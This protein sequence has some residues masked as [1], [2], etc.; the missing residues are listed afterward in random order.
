MSG[1]LNMMRNMTEQLYTSDMTTVGRYNLPTPNF[2]S[3][4]FDQIHDNL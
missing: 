3:R 2:S 1:L 4:Q